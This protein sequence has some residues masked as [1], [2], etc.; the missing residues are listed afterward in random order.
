MFTEITVQMYLD[1]QHQPSLSAEQHC[2]RMLRLGQQKHSTPGIRET[3]YTLCRP[4]K[5]LSDR[6]ELQLSKKIT[7]TK[8]KVQLLVNQCPILTHG[9][10]DGIN[11]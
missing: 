4:S 11:N 6:Q 10:T 3:N 9:T 8:D 2:T 1:I 7:T 5:S